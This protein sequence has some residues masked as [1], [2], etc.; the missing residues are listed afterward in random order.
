MYIIFFQ[1]AFNSRPRLVK[2]NQHFCRNWELCFFCPLKF[3]VFLCYSTSGIPCF[4]KSENNLKF[5][6]PRSDFTA[7]LF[8]AIKFVVKA[9]IGLQPFYLII[10]LC[11]RKIAGVNRYQKNHNLF[12]Q[13]RNGRGGKTLK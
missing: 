12:F 11:R 13:K 6:R 7:I 4:C 8:T 10:N 5:E 9:R 2:K 3:L 1:K